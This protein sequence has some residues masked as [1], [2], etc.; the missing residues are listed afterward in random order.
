MLLEREPFS[1][2]AAGIFA[3]AEQARLEAY[4]CATTVTTVDYL[5]MQAWPGNRAREAPHRLLEF[6]AIAPVN[7]SVI[8]QALKSRMDDFED[9]VPASCRGPGGC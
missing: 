7:R 1:R 9:A 3:L 4:L 6:F 8:E 2:A 5:L